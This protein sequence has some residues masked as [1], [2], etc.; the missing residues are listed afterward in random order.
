M[1]F[2]KNTT[3][4]YASSGQLKTALMIGQDKKL[5]KVLET[6]LELSAKFDESLLEVSETSEKVF[7]IKTPIILELMGKDFKRTRQRSGSDTP[8]KE[9]LEEEVEIYKKIE[10]KPN[11][12]SLTARR[13]LEI[14]NA[15]LGLCEVYV[16]HI[17]DPKIKP[18]LDAFPLDQIL[19]TI[20]HYNTRRQEIGSFSSK[21]YNSN[22]ILKNFPQLHAEAI[23]LK[24]DMDDLKDAGI[25]D[26][27]D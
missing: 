18:L 7:K 11:L 22:D 3:E 13:F 19:A 26:D 8:K 5:A 4:F 6:F 21:I 23:K 9:E 16:P 15:K 27:E 1:N 20:D 24:E 25:F 12:S 14:F 17:H 2:K 10:S